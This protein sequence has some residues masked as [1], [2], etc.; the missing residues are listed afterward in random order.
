MEEQIL[1]EAIEKCLN[2]QLSFE[3]LIAT[4]DIVQSAIF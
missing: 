1:T 4:L 3:E 2:E